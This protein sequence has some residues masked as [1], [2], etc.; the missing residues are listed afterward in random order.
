ME[1]QHAD[2]QSEFEKEKA[3]WDGKFE[4]LDK[5]KDQAKKDNEEALRQFQQTVEQLQKSQNESK[6][7]HEHNHNAIMQQLE[8]KFKKEFKEAAD[9]NM[10]QVT[11]LNNTIR[12]LEKENKGLNERL[13]LNLRSMN[14]E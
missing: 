11:Q 3:L 10:N 6:S 9:S 13:E 8:Q 7:K 1:R 4:F 14:N 2:L 12:R 5:Q